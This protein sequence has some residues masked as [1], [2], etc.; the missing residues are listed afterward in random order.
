METQI[1]EFL[2]E[3]ELKKEELLKEGVSSKQLVKAK[4]K[5]FKTQR[6]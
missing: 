4:I 3:M 5:E 2:Q 6:R 1:E